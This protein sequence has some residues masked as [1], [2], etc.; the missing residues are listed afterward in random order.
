MWLHKILASPLEACT[1][2]LHWVL[3]RER[4][5]RSSSNWGG[6]RPRGRKELGKLKGQEEAV[7][8]RGRVPWNQ[9][10]EVAR[11]RVVQGLVDPGDE[12]WLISCPFRFQLRN[13]DWLCMFRCLLWLPWRRY[14]KKTNREK[15]KE[16][17]EVIQ[18]K[19]SGGL[20]GGGDGEK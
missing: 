20:P 4:T 12:F 5:G 18:V 16:K 8:T 2:K 13:N 7:R 1:H 15:K 19:G 9:V 3:W 17:I 10:E 11:G 14:S 6:V